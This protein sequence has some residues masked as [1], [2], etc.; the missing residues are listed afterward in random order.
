[1]KSGYMKRLTTII[2]TIAFIA[3]GLGIISILQARM[4]KLK[5]VHLDFG[6]LLWVPD[7]KIPHLLALG[8]DDSAADMLWIRSVFYVGA[9][10]VHD[11]EHGHDHECDDEH[12]HCHYGVHVEHEN[13]A[14]EHDS[15]IDHDEAEHQLQS[16]SL[17]PDSVNFMDL[18]L[19]QIPAIQKSLQGKLHRGDAAHMFHLFDVITNLDPQFATPY[20]QGAMYLS[21]M[22][23]RWEEALKL[24]NK[25][26]I[27]RPDVWQIPFYKG[28]IK[29]FY[30]NDKFGA[31][32]ELTRAALQ[33]G[34][35][36]FV[37]QLAAA[38]QAGIGRTEAAIEFLRTLMEI[39]EDEELKK[40]IEETIE[41][42][43]QRKKG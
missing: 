40:Q 8:D 16:A 26:A 1:M 13:E 2:L 9:F 42:Y 17:K 30:Q 39:T 35:P 31:A 14:H 11:H 3:V 34:A 38:L 36:R 20:Y 7:W 28:F 23:G 41:L 37:V 25:G 19:G 10:H 22:T 32:N 5:A 29:L 24:L 43:E 27:N 4:E 12:C 6:E 21:L 15:T 33:K 18:D